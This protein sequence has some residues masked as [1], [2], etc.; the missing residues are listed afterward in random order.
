MRGALVPGGVVPVAVPVV[1]P[2]LPDVPV[3]VT[4]ARVGEAGWLTVLPVGGGVVSAAR[5]R[6]SGE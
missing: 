4:G 6:S 2:E 5:A 1:L 3:P